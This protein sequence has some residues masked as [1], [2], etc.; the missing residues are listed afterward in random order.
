[1]DE[2][3]TPH[4]GYGSGIGLFGY[5]ILFVIIVW[6]FGA[7]FNGGCG[8]FGGFGG[9]GNRGNCGAGVVG[10]GLFANEAL[11]FDVFKSVCDNE[12]ADITRTATTQYLVDQKASETQAVVTAQSRMLAEKIDFYQ[13]QELRDKITERDQKI[14]QLESRVYNDAKFNELSGQ[15]AGIRCNMLTRPEISGVGVA[16]PNSAILNGLGINSLYNRN[17]GCNNNSLNYNIV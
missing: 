2:M 16:C 6:V 11:T 1:M 13:Y 4:Y 9:W 3:N 8:G 7:A 15:I 17:C 10:T 5:I 12:K 14:M